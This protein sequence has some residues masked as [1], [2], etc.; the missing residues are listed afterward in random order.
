MRTTLKTV[1][2]ALIG[3]LAFSGLTVST[4]SANDVLLKKKVIA[5]KTINP[6]NSGIGFSKGV[7]FNSGFGFNNGFGHSS[8]ARNSFGVTTLGFG[9]SSLG[10]GTSKFISPRFNRGLTTR[11]FN[12][13]SGLVS[14]RGLS[15]RRT[16]S[17]GFIR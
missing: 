13:R 12:S 11:G 8:F 2:L 14:R 15:S 17:R 9:K 7:G 1:G 10:F 5:A 3:T 6:I 16:L 4:A